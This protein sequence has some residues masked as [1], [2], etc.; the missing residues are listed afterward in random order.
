M[1]V[2]RG[3]KCG[4]RAMHAPK[5]LVVYVVHNVIIAILQTAQLNR[6]P[7]MTGKERVVD[8]LAF[9][10]YMCLRMIKPYVVKISEIF[11]S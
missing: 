11:A 10:D 7:P 5:I 6:P 3:G 1:F 4:L 9:A 8:F 2:E